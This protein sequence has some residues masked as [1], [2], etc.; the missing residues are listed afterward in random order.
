MGHFSP[1]EL[2][3][4]RESYPLLDLEI[5]AEKCLAWYRGK[6]EHIRDARAVF[7]KWLERARP[8]DRKIPPSKANHSRLPR[9]EPLW[10]KPPLAPSSEAEALWG[11]CKELLEVRVVGPIYK[12]WISP[13]K[14]F[15]VDGDVVWVQAE[16]A[17]AAEWVDRRI[18]R[19]CEETLRD[20]GKHNAELHLFVE[21][22]LGVADANSIDVEGRV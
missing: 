8:P 16:T 21:P 12:T 7:R 20:A 11:K 5:E 18:L 3:D 10:E 13:T 17:A 6:G 15:A 2:V 22:S 1:Q 9:D 4:L 14:G 19:L